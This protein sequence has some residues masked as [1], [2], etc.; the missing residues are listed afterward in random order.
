[1]D[2]SYKKSRPSCYGKEHANDSKKCM[3]CHYEYDCDGEQPRLKQQP[4]KKPEPSIPMQLECMQTAVPNSNM[5]LKI[6]THA[7]VWL[8]CKYAGSR[9]Q[10]K[11][12]N[13]E[14]FPILSC[15]YK[16]RCKGETIVNMSELEVNV[17][18][19]PEGDMI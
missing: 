4:V 9:T 17:N 6:C 2:S 15:K 7:A 1:M 8:S 3:V 10:F 16:G 14:P 12:K 18:L 13:T 11:Y 19:I 5:L